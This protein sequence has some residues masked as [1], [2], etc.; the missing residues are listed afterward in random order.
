M[1]PTLIKANIALFNG[2]R[3]EARRLLD[4]FRAGNPRLEP[5]DSTFLMWL[6]AQ[7]QDERA[8][9]LEKLRLLADKGVKSSRYVTMAQE[10]LAVEEQ[11]KVG[12][13]DVPEGDVVPGKP[14][15]QLPRLLGVELWK[16]GTFAVAG[17]VVGTRLWAIADI[18]PP[19][20]AQQTAA[21]LPDSA[22]TSAPPTAGPDRSVRIAPEDHTAQYPQGIVELSAFEDGSQRVGNLNGVPLTP[23]QGTR[24]YALR[25]RFECRSGGVCSR[26]P[27]ASVVLLTDGNA[28]IPP[29]DNA[30]IIGESLLQPIGNLS[31]TT[32]WLVFEL[33]E[34]SQ[35]AALVLTPPAA[36]GETPQPILIP[37][38]QATS[39]TE[40]NGD[41]HA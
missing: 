26:P 21:P 12:G 28:A 7:A 32:G 31:S 17:I 8:A 36:T 1:N 41:V 22:A 37:L 23:V 2:S 3:S 9:R 38:T 19:S 25:V 18:R 34:N 16:V 30:G 10:T 11:A 39:A 27:E 6:D 40:G 13:R 24:F 14:G 4:E 33:P 29:V 5:E 35:A 20:S 15:R